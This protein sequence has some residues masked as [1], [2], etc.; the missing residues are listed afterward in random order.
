MS[1]MQGDRAYRKSC[2]IQHDIVMNVQSEAGLSRAPNE[3]DDMTQTP[4]KV[5]MT[6]LKMSLTVIWMQNMHMPIL[7]R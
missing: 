6:G 4:M 3:D 5:Y 1:Y 7:I 2:P